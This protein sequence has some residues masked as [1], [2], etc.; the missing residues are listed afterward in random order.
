MYTLLDWLAVAIL[1]LE[2]TT[3]ERQRKESPQ[4]QMNESL[5]LQIKDDKKESRVM[6]K[7][8]T[9]SRHCMYPIQLSTHII[10]ANVTLQRHLR[11]P[12]PVRRAPTKV[13]Q[14]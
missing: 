7:L 10:R 11:Q 14:E 13:S 4:L 5:K 9:T 2:Q 12:F 8:C 1:Q 3:R 6:Q